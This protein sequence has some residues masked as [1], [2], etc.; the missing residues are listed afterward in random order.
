MHWALAQAIGMGGGLRLTLLSIADI[1]EQQKKRVAKKW[2][3]IMPC[4]SKSCGCILS[5]LM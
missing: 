1:K 3:K 4:R 2:T 5:D